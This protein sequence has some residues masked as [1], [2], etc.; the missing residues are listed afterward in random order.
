MYVLGALQAT[1]GLLPNLEEFYI[2]GMGIIMGNLNIMCLAG[3]NTN[4]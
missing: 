1:L 2:Q 4:L 3:P